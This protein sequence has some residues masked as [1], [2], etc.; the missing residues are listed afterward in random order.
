MMLNTYLRLCTTGGLLLLSYFMNACHSV[1]VTGRS[2]LNMASEEEVI[3]MSA[4]AFQ[5]IKNQNRIS[6]NPKYQAIVN[7]V[8]QRIADANS[9]DIQNANW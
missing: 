5:S 7:K 2:A 4:E 9:W 3:K 8:G 6:K 1:P